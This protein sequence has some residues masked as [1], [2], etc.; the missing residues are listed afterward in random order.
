M[1]RLIKVSDLKDQTGIGP[2]P[3]LYCELCGAELP[4]NKGDYFMCSR[5]AT[6]KCCEIPM[7]L[8]IKKIT[9]EEVNF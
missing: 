6:F 9:Y 4:A 1:S 7:K 2:E 8:V 5:K 3:I